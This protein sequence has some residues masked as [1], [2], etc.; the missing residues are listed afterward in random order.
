MENTQYT[1]EIPTLQDLLIISRARE[2]L[3]IV[4]DRSDTSTT[5]FPPHNRSMQ[6]A[7]NELKIGNRRHGLNIAKTDNPIQEIV[8]RLLIPDQPDEQT[9]KQNFAE[10]LHKEIYHYQEEAAR[11]QRACC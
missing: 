1:Q 9:N 5:P 6:T 10:G 8:S 2:I 3:S 7:T 4:K 11:A